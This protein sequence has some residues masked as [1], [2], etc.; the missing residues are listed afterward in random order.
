MSSNEISKEEDSLKRKEICL[1]SFN[2]INIRSLK[3]HTDEVNCCSFSP[4]LKFIVTGSDDFT[5]KI[6]NIN[7]SK[8]VSSLSGHAGH[9]SC[10][11]AVAF[12]PDDKFLISGS[13]DR[14]AI[15][16]NLECSLPH[17]V[18]EGHNSVVQCCT[19]SQDGKTIATG[20]WDYT[21]QIWFF[22]KMKIIKN[23]VLKGH[24]GNI[25][26]LSFSCDDIL[27]SASWD[28]TVR[29]WNIY[30]C[31]CLHILQG[32]MGWIQACSF[33]PLG[34]YLVTAADDKLVKIWNV[35][36]GE[37]LKD[38][39]KRLGV[40]IRGKPKFEFTIETKDLMLFAMKCNVCKQ[41]IAA[42]ELVKR[43][44][45]NVYHLHCF[46]CE[47]CGRTLEKGDEFGLK[48]RRLY[49][50]EDLNGIKRE[51]ESSPDSTIGSD[52]SEPASPAPSDLSCDT[53]S[54]K[55][56]RTILTSSQR[57]A[58]KAAFE[59]TPKPC[60]KVR[61]ELSRDTGLSVRVVQVWFQNQRAKLKKM[62]KKNNP[63][64]D[65][66]AKLIAKAKKKHK[67]KVKSNSAETNKKRACL[68]EC[69]ESIK[70]QTS[71][72]SST[73]ANQMQPYENLRGDNNYP[74]IAPP[75]LQP[76]YTS[77]T[78]QNADQTSCFNNPSQNELAAPPPYSMSHMNYQVQDTNNVMENR[79][80]G[81]Y[82]FGNAIGSS[83][84]DQLERG[85]THNQIMNQTLNS[86]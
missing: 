84:L 9:H 76:F 21:V 70:D 78:Q 82:E 8:I 27:A 86:Y 49:C 59:M 34:K 35:I 15:L 56:P 2:T 4:D 63:P 14:T 23:K 6:W 47:E 31:V 33:C 69:G 12:S 42:N 3:G 5:L 45:Q 73:F 50:K 30:E 10:I 39:K 18:I 48:D 22:E 7:D 29:L 40:E 44:M 80:Q 37:C 54:P 71:T 13:W 79:I 28:C 55:R 51:K 75:N 38:L 81:F 85:R 52:K 26:A 65:H 20:S 67:S 77:T 74:L 68:Q 11:E 24:T 57:K 17:I 43:A 66:D 61:E 1:D 16:W 64:H 72:S 36:S 25:K 83:F 62:A 19:F 41:G 53:K 46:K 58:F 60:R 32:H